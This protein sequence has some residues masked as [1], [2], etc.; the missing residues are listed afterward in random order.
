MGVLDL[1]F[2]GMFFFDL[3]DDFE[4]LVEGEVVEVIFIYEV[5]DLDGDMF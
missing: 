4:F 3:N 5:F 2:D 1:V